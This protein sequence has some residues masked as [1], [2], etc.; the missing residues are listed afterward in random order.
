MPEGKEP[1]VHE[2]DD[3]QALLR[4]GQ[5]QGV[6]SYAEIQDGLSENEEL[7]IADIEEVYRVITD[8]GIR[9]VDDEELEEAEEEDDTMVDD[10]LEELDEVPIDDSVRMYLRDIGRVSL[11]SAHEEVEL[12]RRIQKGDGTVFFD[13]TANCLCFTPAERL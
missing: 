1:E 9:I 11:L 5:R 4:K 13:K 6:L 10:E 7:D 12:A 3:V 2:L 8:A